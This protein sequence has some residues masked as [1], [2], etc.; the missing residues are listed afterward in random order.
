MNDELV[1]KSRE[2]ARSLRHRPDRWGLTL[3]KAGWCSVDA[4]L[5]GARQHGVEIS[6]EQLRE[7]VATNDKS[8]FALSPD[9]LKI[10]AVQGHSVA[11]E[12]GL[13]NRAPP[14]MLYHGTVRKFMNAIRREGLQPMTRHAVHLS[15]TKEAAL[16]VGRRRGAAVL[17]VVDSF[18]MHRDGW[19]FQC[20]DNGVWLV[21]AVPPKYLKP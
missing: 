6:D 11:V 13:A 19:V 9:G 1:N 16:A 18:A 17:L 5:T 3:D 10:R 21:A 14:S 15:S 7:I 20:S 12:L 8:R 2:M 4:L